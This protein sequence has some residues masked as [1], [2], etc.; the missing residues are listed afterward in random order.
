MTTT[1]TRAAAMTITAMA[2]RATPTATRSTRST[3]TTE[4]RQGPQDAGLVFCA[5]RNLTGSDAF[6]AQ[7]G[8]CEVALLQLHVE[9]VH[10]LVVVQAVDEIA[11]ALEVVDGLQGAEEHRHVV[12]VD[13]VGLLQADQLAVLVVQVHREDLPAVLVEVEAAR[14]VGV[15]VALA[16]L[17]VDH[18]D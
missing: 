18:P 7:G 11:V 12:V 16:Q 17:G 3:S 5:W 8:G 15:A 10:R 4:K 14:A 2:T 13:R 1:V 6:A 9:V